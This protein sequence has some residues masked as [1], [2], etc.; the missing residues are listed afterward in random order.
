MRRTLFAALAVA[1]LSSLSAI[2]QAQSQ[3]FESQNG[4]GTNLP[5]GSSTEQVQPQQGPGM[6]NSSTPADI[7]PA[8]TPQP[9]LSGTQSS[10]SSSNYGTSPSSASTPSTVTPS[11]G[12]FASDSQRDPSAPR[13]RESVQSETL[14]AMRLGAIVQGEATGPEAEQN[15]ER[16][17]HMLY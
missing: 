8:T 9:G 11:T 12:A 16:A 4:P 3:T 5:S 1:A 6:G 13:T 10:P 2:A 14:K 7:N 17:L 15:Q